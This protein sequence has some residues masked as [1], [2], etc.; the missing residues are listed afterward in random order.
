M[1]EPTN[2]S[3]T[4]DGENMVELDDLVYNEGIILAGGYDG[5]LWLSSLDLYS[6]L[7]D[8]LNSLKPMSSFRSYIVIASLSREVYVCG[9]KS[10]EE[11]YKSGNASSPSLN[12]PSSP[13]LLSC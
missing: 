12:I 11:W 2:P 4:H 6:P 1:L 10:G 8:V 5:N 3:H 9:G 7:N 13:F